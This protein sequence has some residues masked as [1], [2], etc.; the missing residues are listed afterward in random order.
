LLQC[1]KNTAIIYSFSVL[2]LFLS[3]S[4]KKSS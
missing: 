4:K 2:N 3:S 1:F